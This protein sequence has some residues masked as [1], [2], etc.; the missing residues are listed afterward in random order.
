MI[1]KGVTSF[2]T[3]LGAGALPK[4]RGSP[5]VPLRAPFVL[6]SSL[7][8]CVVLYSGPARS[9]LNPE[10]A[11]APR[12]SLGTLEGTVAIGS[13][14]RSRTTRIRLYADPIQASQV[15]SREAEVE[16]V[17]V[18]LESVSSD[19]GEGPPRP[20]RLV[21]EQVNETFVPHV[22]PI[23][24]GDIVTFPNRDPVFHNVF[25]LSGAR[26]FDLGRYPKPSSRS[27]RFDKPGVVKVFCHIHSDMSAV[28]VVLENPF[29]AIPGPDGRFR[30]TGIPSGE[31]KLVTWHERARPLTR[32][33]R[34]AA[35]GTS[36]V[37]LRIPLQDAGDS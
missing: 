9:G 37:T 36:L 17:V 35:G 3:A 23:L 7:A 19:I 14:L 26:T 13:R 25:S 2:R 24:K 1:S 20:R 11:S 28:I 29:F 12:T 31:Y 33:V 6:L 5:L 16:N 22:L 27:V 32:R 8:L 30:I 34:I 15:P 4:G 18:Y 10:P 21:I